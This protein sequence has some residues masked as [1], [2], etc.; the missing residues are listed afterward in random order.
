MATYIRQLSDNAGNNILPATRSEAVYMSDDTTLQDLVASSGVVKKAQGDKNG[1]DI[2]SYISGLSVSGRTITFTKG[3]GTDDTITT[4]DTTYQNATTGAAGLMSAAD[5]T[6][7]DSIEENANNYTHPS[8][9][10]AG[11]GLYKV[12]VDNLGHVTATKAV[13]K[14]DITALGIPGQDT[15]YSEFAG[16]TAGLVP[17]ADTGD[18]GKYLKADGTWGTPE[19]T[20]YTNASQSAAGL[21]SADDK[22]KLDG[23]ET[24]AN[25]YTHPSYDDQPSGLYK[26]TVDA[27]G[28]VSAVT[29]VVKNDITAL[30]I[31]AQ[32]T[33]YQNASQSS[34]GLMSA[35]DKTKLDN[36]PSNSLGYVEGW[37]KAAE[38]LPELS[39]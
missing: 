4:Q 38:D 15:T 19:N 11:E 3:D 24:G 34:A 22:K 1:K 6:K 7:L 29:P 23:I 35:A 30:G 37:G 8:H 26:V 9:S 2:T 18:A 31:P 25:K 27:T 5:K 16:S 17:S 28:H 32:D 36:I 13:Q 39:A 14:G 12:T 10:A 21:M 20:T 33:T